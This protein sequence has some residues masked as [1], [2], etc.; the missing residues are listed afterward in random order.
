MRHPDTGETLTDVNGTRVRELNRRTFDH[1]HRSVFAGPGSEEQVLDLSAPKPGSGL[2]R[3]R[4]ELP[5]RPLER[6]DPEG[7]AM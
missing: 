4:G 3:V 7:R 1:A 6:P 5:G 2:R